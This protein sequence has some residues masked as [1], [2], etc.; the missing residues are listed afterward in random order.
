[1]D[2]VN[3]DQ[4]RKHFD[5]QTRSTHA[6]VARYEGF[7]SNG[8]I[9]TIENDSLKQSILAYYQQTIPAVND[10][11]EV[12]NKIQDRLMDAEITKAEK[13]S[14][15]AFAKSFKALGYLEVTRENLG[16]AILTYADA[17]AQAMKIIGMIDLY[18]KRKD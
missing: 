1:M 4:I 13:M 5:F 11:E 7:K 10:I 6:N 2:T 8:K 17:E 3:E 9:G 16:P 14:M 12:V 18:L 15:R